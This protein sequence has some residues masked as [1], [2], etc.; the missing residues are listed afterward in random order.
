MNRLHRETDGERRIKRLMSEMRSDAVPIP[1]PEPPG[2]QNA[3]DYLPAL[4]GQDRPMTPKN[5]VRCCGNRI[6]ANLSLRQHQSSSNGGTLMNDFYQEQI[7]T[8]LDQDG[9][10]NV[11]VSSNSLNCWPPSS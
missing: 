5:L 2:E 11:N 1:E 10:R 7:Q 4:R 6:G 3:S 8:A 9:C